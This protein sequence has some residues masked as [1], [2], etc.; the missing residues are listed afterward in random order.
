MTGRSV[1]P[2]P[3]LNTFTSLLL[4]YHI[5][6]GTYHTHVQ[7]LHDSYG[8]IVRIGYSQ[9]SISNPTELKRILST[10]S[11]RKGSDYE[12]V[13]F[14][15]P[16]IFTTTDPELNKTRRRQ[17]GNSYSLPSVRLYEDKILQHGVISLMTLWDSQIASSPSQDKTLVNFHYCFHGMAFDIIGMLGFGN[18]F[19]ILSTGDMTMVYLARKTIVYGILNSIVPFSD[20]LYWLLGDYIK[21]RDM[22]VKY[23][24]DTVLSRKSATEGTHVDILQRLVNAYDPL[25][26]KGLD[27]DSLTTEVFFM[28]FSSTDTTSNTLSWIVLHLLYNPEVYK[29]LKHEVRS[30]FTDKSAVIFYDMARIQLPYL[31]AVV[32]ESMRLHPAVSGYVPRQVPADGAHIMDGQYFVPS[33][34]TLCISF[35]ASHRNRNVWANPNKFDPERFMG[36]DAEDRIKDVLAFSS[37]VRNCVGRF[38]ALAEIYTTLANLILRYDFRLPDKAKARHRSVDDIPSASINIPLNY[39]IA[40]GRYHTYIGALHAMYGEVV[41][42]GYNQVSVSNL[43]ELKRILSTHDFRKGQMYEDN[44]VIAVNSFSA[45]DPTTSKA[46]RRQ[47]GSSYSLPS[48]RLYEDKVLGHG[49]LS[50]MQTWNS[51]LMLS[52]D[53]KKKALVNFYY[54]FHGLA[55]DIIGVLG[56]GNSFNILSTGD[57]AIIDQVSKTLNLGI[58]QSSLPFGNYVHRLFRGM[59]NSR[60]TLI[61]NTMNTIKKRQQENAAAR[62]SG[63]EHSAHVDVLQRLV[64]AHDS[65]TGE[66]LDDESIKSEMLLMLAAGTDTT[67][68]TLVWAT[69]CLLHFPGVYKQLKED[70]RTAF[71]DKATVIRYDMARSRVPYLTAFLYEV[72]RMYPTVSGYLPRRVPPKGAYLMNKYHVPFGTEVCVSIGACHRSSIVWEDPEKFDPSRFMGPDAEDRFRDVLAF[73]A[74]VRICIGRFLGLVELY[75]TMANLVHKYDFELPDSIKGKYGSTEDIPG[76]SFITFAPMYPKNDCWM[77]V[78]QAN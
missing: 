22:L 49:V 45:I 30:T 37:G 27:Q 70:I 73:S 17:L 18:S 33:D 35:Y 46:K 6:R 60:D 3:F 58:L 12:T 69:M 55:F 38:L 28:L 4:N 36:A 43:D 39:N 52:Q 61:E 66:K 32:Y 76:S 31:T 13:R 23:S 11:F 16:S 51:Q 77:L 2:G 42:V 74:G 8:E 25:T 78:S 68:N 15:P 47:I 5:V 63:K 40:R 7:K 65:L 14:L 19:N 67:S 29:R 62:A 53:T 21:A 71:P 56:F 24:R 9:V 59:V 41:R 34:T 44:G 26:K 54:G 10:H 50:L 20:H 48:V 75:T 72:M 57:T 1:V 64:D